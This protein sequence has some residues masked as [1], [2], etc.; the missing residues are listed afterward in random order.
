MKS[1]FRRR[2]HE[3]PIL[4]PRSA[5]GLWRRLL[6]RRLAAL[7]PATAPVVA[8]IVGG[9]S[10]LV[11]AAMLVGGGRDNPPADA[12]L[13]A[14]A[15]PVE[16]QSQEAAPAATPEAGPAADA[17][18]ESAGVPSG[19]R[20]VDPAPRATADRDEE[21]P[22]APSPAPTP[23]GQRTAAIPPALPGGSR[24]GASTVPVAETEEE[25]LALEA[26]QRGEVE[27]DVG[28][29]SDERTAAIEEEPAAR[30][31]PA[32]T[33]QYV[34]LRAAPD[35][36][37]EVIEVVPALASIEAEGG[38]NWCAVSHEG[39]RGYIYKTFISYE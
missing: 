7:P 26:I 25:I 4:T 13:A 18:E 35:D 10:M 34:N 15:G 9:V 3:K 8:T 33:T 23:D 22:A 31:L 6:S 1:L 20:N 39:R 28:Q 37:S 29:P 36:D 2:P 11:V 19:S 24:M 14:A 21:Q 27:Q 38:C 5:A 32:R 12:D 16:D 30:L 17:T